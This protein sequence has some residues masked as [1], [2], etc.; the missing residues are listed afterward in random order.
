MKLYDY[1]RSSAAYRVRIALHWKNLSF[2]QIPINIA[3]GSDEQL[4]ADYAAI[5]PQM[6]VPSLDSGAGLLAQS[7]AIIEWLEETHP[8]PPLLPR[9]PVARARCRSLSYVIACDIH[10]LNN[11]A[12]L[13]YLRRQL[14]ADES[15]VNAWYRHWITLGF[16]A[17]EAMVADCSTDFAFGATPSLFEVCLTPQVANARRFAVDLSPFQT[18]ARFDAAARA[19]PAFAAAAPE[20]QPG[21]PA[22]G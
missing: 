10:P 4:S 14:G 8:S 20:R 12:P 18:L 22:T 9:D 5:N 6:R 15:Q 19:L 11:L 3:P 2:D 21:A 16:Q 13:G 7:L 1:W 17:L